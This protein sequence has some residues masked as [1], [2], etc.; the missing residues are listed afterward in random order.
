[1]YANYFSINLEEKKARQDL[2]T[3]GVWKGGTWLVSKLGRSDW[4]ATGGRI[5][6]MKPCWASSYD[7]PLWARSDWSRKGKGSLHHAK[8]KA[9]EQS[10]WRDAISAKGV[11][12]APVSP[13]GPWMTCSG[14]AQ[15]L[16]KGL[17]W[18]QV[19]ETLFW[20][21]SFVSLMPGVRKTHLPSPQGRENGEENLRAGRMGGQGFTDSPRNTSRGNWSC[22]RT[23]R[24]QVSTN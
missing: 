10:S 8:T 4:G 5:S 15:V 13:K 1:M 24:L 2:A 7:E 23:L 21:P 3:A 14:Q 9:G 12:G 6:E 19:L 18:A 11:P 16:S 17:S 20:F 22:L